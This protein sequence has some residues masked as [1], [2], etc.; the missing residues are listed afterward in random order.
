MSTLHEDEMFTSDSGAGGL[1]I[2]AAQLS[3]GLPPS[4][5]GGAPH[6]PALSLD[7]MYSGAHRAG[8]GLP[9]AAAPGLPASPGTSPRA[10][11]PVPAWWGAD[12]QE[13]FQQPPLW[14]EGGGEAQPQHSLLSKGLQQA[15]GTGAA[16]GYDTGAGTAGAGPLHRGGSGSFA[17]HDMKTS[18]QKLET[19]SFSPHAPSSGSGGS[20]MPGGP[21][22]PHR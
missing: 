18:P 9:L 1:P 12:Q 21:F 10:D 20:S 11:E 4:R 5:L 16:S 13:H 14:A 6:S 7:S 17:P 3:P 8:G 2:A 19:A 15:A 22:G